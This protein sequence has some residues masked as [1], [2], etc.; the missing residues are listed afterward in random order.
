MKGMH[1]GYDPEQIYNDWQA[2]GLSFEDY[3]VGLKQEDA[4]PWQ[5][6]NP[7]PI[8]RSQ[9]F[10]DE[11]QANFRVFGDESWSTGRGPHIA[12]GIITDSPPRPPDPNVRIQKIETEL[13]II[14]G[15]VPTPKGYR[16]NAGRI[17]ELM[18]EL[19][20]LRKK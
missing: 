5:V 17:K 16:V 19:R 13:D 14:R 15:R 4:D 10:Y 1:T 20:Q 18:T 11:Q 9:A 7:P 8:D 12:R 3:M 6:N 2:S